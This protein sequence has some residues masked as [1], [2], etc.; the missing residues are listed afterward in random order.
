MPKAKGSPAD[1]RI[2]ERLRQIRRAKRMSQSE[3]GEALGVT[4]QQIQKYELG[5]S[6][7]SVSTLLKAAEAFGISPADFYGSAD[8]NTTSQS[9]SRSRKLDRY[10]ASEEGQAVLRAFAGIRRADIRHEL[11]KLAKALGNR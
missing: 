2:G 4:Y 6:R 8:P 7:M 10:A 3:L 11:I 5:H 9:G 1:A